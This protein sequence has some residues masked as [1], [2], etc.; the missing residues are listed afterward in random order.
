MFA[1]GENQTDG[2]M[3]V[4]RL[5]NKAVRGSGKFD[6]QGVS[7]FNRPLK[8]SLKAAWVYFENN[9]KSVIPGVRITD[10]DY[11]LYFNDLQSRGGCTEISVAEW[12]GLCS[13]LADR[14]VVES[15]AVIGEIKISGSMSEVTNLESILRVAENAGARRLLLPMECMKELVQLPGELLTNVQPVFYNNPL[16]AARKAMNF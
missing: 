16:D 13:A 2:E 12:I 3:S 5:E 7:S 1:I 15:M 14:P 4:Y 8:D 6:Q 9:A 11:F 10:R